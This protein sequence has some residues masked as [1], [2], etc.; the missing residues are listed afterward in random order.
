MRTISHDP[1]HGDVQTFGRCAVT[2]HDAFIES[3]ESGGCYQDPFDDGVVESRSAEGLYLFDDE[4]S[5]RQG[6][7]HIARSCGGEMPVG[8]YALT[9]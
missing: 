5:M 1:E 4:E 9:V 3:H 6:A 8:I 2:N 7:Q